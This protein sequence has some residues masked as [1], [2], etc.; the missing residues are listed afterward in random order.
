LPTTPDVAPK[1]SDEPL[2]SG[3]TQT[4]AL[5]AGSPAINAGDD[6]ICAAAAVNQ[7]DQRGFT[8][9]GTDHPRCSIG[10]YE[11]E[12]APTGTPSSGPTSTPLRLPSV[13][14]SPQP[15]ET[16]TVV[17]TASSGV[18]GHGGLCYG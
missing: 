13:T 1:F 10:T 11:F 14:P 16:P 4:I 2:I 6:A 7:L 9:P 17:P 3:A 5:Q 12:G 15:T 8:R 18:V